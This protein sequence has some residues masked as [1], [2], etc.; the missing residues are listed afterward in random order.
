MWCRLRRAAI[1]RLHSSRRMRRRHDESARHTRAAVRGRR[2]D[3]TNGGITDIVR[4]ALA[5]DRDSKSRSRFSTDHHSSSDAR[6]RSNSQSFS[7]IICPYPHPLATKPASFSQSHNHDVSMSQTHMS[8]ANN[9]IFRSLVSTRIGGFVLRIRMQGDSAPIQQTV[10]SQA[11]NPSREVSSVRLRSCR[12]RID[13]LPGVLVWT[14]PLTDDPR[15]LGAMQPHR[16]RLESGGGDPRA[17]GGVEGT[18]GE[19]STRNMR[20]TSAYADRTQP[21]N[22]NQPA[23]SAGG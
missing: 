17:Q 8:D 9:A 1:T 3:R 18:G 21:R 23:Q 16:M 20:S 2:E 12:C 6:E 11:M 19:R 22:A 4:V 13:L 7:G 15:W 14:H 10:K 5:S